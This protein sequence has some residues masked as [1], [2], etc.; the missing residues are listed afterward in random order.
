MRC[1]LIVAAVPSFSAVSPAYTE[2]RRGQ[3]TR[4]RA[5]SSDSRL[6]GPSH[7]SD[8]ERTPLLAA[9]R[10]P[11]ALQRGRTRPWCWPGS[12]WHEAGEAGDAL[13]HGGGGRWLKERHGPW[14][15]WNGCCRRRLGWCCGAFVEKVRIWARVCSAP[16]PKRRA[17]PLPRRPEPWRVPLASTRIPA[18]GWPCDGPPRQKTLCSPRDLSTD[19]TLVLAA[20]VPRGTRKRS[21]T[22]AVPIV[23]PVLLLLLLL[24]PPLRLAARPSVPPFVYHHIPTPRLQTVT[25]PGFRLGTLERPSAPSA[26]SAPSHAA[27]RNPPALPTKPSRPDRFH[28]FSPPTAP[29]ATSSVLLFPPHARTHHPHQ[30]PTPHPHTPLAGFTY[31]GPLPILPPIPYFALH[32]AL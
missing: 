28:F 8:G 32:S 16:S 1:M 30:P 9:T 25:R 29:V 13:A 6:T 24:C 12:R 20:T 21:F 4:R 31:H 2:Q 7:D 22:L 18:W 14:M 27:E 11:E 17:L 15:E 5:R 26:P 19:L 3:C 23:P 10:A